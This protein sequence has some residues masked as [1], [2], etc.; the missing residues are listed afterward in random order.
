M[1]LKFINPN[2]FFQFELTIIQVHNSNGYLYQGP[3]KIFLIKLGIK[4]LMYLLEI[5]TL[6][7]NNVIVTLTKIMNPTNKN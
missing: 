1:K 4:A 7:L 3:F 2:S 6:S 5:S